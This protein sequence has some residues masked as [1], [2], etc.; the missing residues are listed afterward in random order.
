VNVHHEALV[1]W[2]WLGNKKECCLGAAGLR[3]CSNESRTS[4]HR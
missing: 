3:T 2:R 4:P 1:K